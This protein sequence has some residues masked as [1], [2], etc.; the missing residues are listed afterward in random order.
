[1]RG[2][3]TGP[4]MDTPPTGKRVAFPLM[5]VYRLAG[6]KI[7]QHWMLVDMVSFMQQIGAMPAPA[8]A[9]A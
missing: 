2:V 4:F 3:H 6:G 9:A 8:E 5:I 7:V 1:V